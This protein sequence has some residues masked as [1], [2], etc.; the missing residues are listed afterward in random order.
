MIRRFLRKLMYAAGGMG[1]LRVRVA[2]NREQYRQ[3]VRAPKPVKK[4]ERRA[5][6]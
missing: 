6:K 5:R 2:G 3:M 4:V 1:S